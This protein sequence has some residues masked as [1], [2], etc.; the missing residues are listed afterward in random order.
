MSQVMLK[1]AD[2]S[3]NTTNWTHRSIRNLPCGAILLKCLKKLSYLTCSGFMQMK[4]RSKQR[5]EKKI[6]GCVASK[7]TNKYKH[8]FILWMRCCCLACLFLF[9]YIPCNTQHALVSR[10]NP[11][12]FQVPNCAVEPSRR[13]A[14]FTERCM[15][16]CAE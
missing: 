6:T 12:S 13:R 5:K 15:S 8:N 2:V 7:R 14:N 4:N 1:V 3:T 11:K 9:S 10:M 16:E